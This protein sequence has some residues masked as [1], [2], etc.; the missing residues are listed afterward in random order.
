[1]CIRDRV[2]Y[3]L[4]LSKT[5]SAK[6]VEWG[7]E[8]VRRAPDGT[9]LIWDPIY[10]QH[11]SDRNM[12]VTQDDLLDAGWIPVVRFKHSH[13]YCDIYLSPRSADGSQTREL[14]EE[15]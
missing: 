5:D 2:Y 12:I 4:D 13:A 8:N 3:Y 1:M 10:G 9:V 6:A 7:R 15:Q 11:N 14:L